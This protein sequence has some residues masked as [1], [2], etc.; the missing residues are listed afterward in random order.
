MIMFTKVV[1]FVK[2]NRVNIVRKGAIAIGSLVGLLAVGVVL[3][4]R[5]PK[6]EEGA[7]A[8]SSEPAEET[9]S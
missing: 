8:D 6:D 1:D 9:E 3:N 5:Q 7:I 2:A 4:N